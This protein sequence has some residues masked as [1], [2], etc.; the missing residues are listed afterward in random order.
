METRTTT[1]A[2]AEATALDI[3]GM[4]CA[5]CAR[6]IERALTNV[7]GVAD[8]RVNLVTQQA[9]VAIDSSRTN[10]A[11]LEAAVV[12]AGYGVLPP[13]PSVGPAGVGR[14]ESEERDRRGLLRDLAV[15]AALTV[16]L[17]VLGMSH[18][19]ISF[20]DTGAGRSMQFALG[21]A[22]LFGPGRRFLRAGVAAAR[23]RSPDMNTLVSLGALSA[24]GWSTA[25]T[26]AAQWLAHG[27]HA[28]PHVYF[29][30]AAA[31]ITF[32][33]FGK[34]LETRARWRLGDALRA[35]HALVP[36]MAHR[37]EGDAAS[38]GGMSRWL[39]CGRVIACGC[40]RV[41]VFRAM[42]SWCTE[43]Q[44]STSRCSAARACRRRRAWVT[45]SSVAA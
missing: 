38:P 27:E 45:A 37:V 6:R 1:P 14:S 32:V 35:L 25:A 12:A 4:T 7:D 24:W 34:F 42:A 8:A 40:G 44:P 16:P 30:A 22:V 23:H 10:R 21:T 2:P 19:A 26:F 28:A 15:A 18:G 3:T 31:I 33:L 11:A 43:V 9:R 41:S 29:E 20:A 5:A 36:A 39:T 17:L 13:A